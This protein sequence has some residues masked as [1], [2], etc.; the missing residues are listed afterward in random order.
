[1]R[2]VGSRLGGKG[3]VRDAPVNGDKGEDVKAV[4]KVQGCKVEELVMVRIRYQISFH[5]A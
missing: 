5:R 4:D 2:L 1:M 3:G